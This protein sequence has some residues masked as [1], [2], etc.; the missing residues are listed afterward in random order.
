[1]EIS[2]YI[3]R[4]LVSMSWFMYLILLW[5]R[6][7][8]NWNCIWIAEVSP[9]NV[10]EWTE[11]QPIRRSRD[12]CDFSADNCFTLLY[13]LVRD[14][15]MKSITYKLCC[16]L[17]MEMWVL[18]L[19]ILKS[20]VLLRESWHHLENYTTLSFSS[21]CLLRS[22]WVLWAFLLQSGCKNTKARNAWQKP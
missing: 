4:D 21:F 22:V 7:E 13:Y 14:L 18:I 15:L 16:L 3:C 17:I 20:S 11:H 2:T 12:P 10:D 19:V 5:R 9:G 8:L 6:R 1:M